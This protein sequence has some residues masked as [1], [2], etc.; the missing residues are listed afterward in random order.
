MSVDDYARWIRP[1]RWGALVQLSEG[2]WRTTWEIEL[3]ALDVTGLDEVASGAADAEAGFTP[4]LSARGSVDL[5]VTVDTTRW[6]MELD[7]YDLTYRLFK[8]ID[9]RLGRIRR[10]QGTPREWWRPFR[11]G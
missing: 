6:A 2:H 9:A 1:V 11:S 4:R 10:I 5:L 7:Y 8:V 3:E